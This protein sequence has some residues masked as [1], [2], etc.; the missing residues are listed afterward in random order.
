[1]GL[2]GGNGPEYEHWFNPQ[3]CANRHFLCNTDFQSF[4]EGKTGT[5]TPYLGGKI[6]GD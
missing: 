6:R 1:M 4:G 3:L 2:G 5:K